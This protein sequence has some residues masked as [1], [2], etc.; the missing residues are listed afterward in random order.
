VSLAAG[1]SPL[2][3]AR[4]VSVVA[5]FPA[6]ADAS[7]QEELLL[8]EWL[9]PIGDKLEQFNVPPQMAYLAWELG[10]WQR[11]LDECERRCAIL[12]VLAASVQTHQGST[13]LDLDEELPRLIRD[14]TGC[15]EAGA[16][17][18]CQTAWALIGSGRLATIAGSSATDFKPLILVGKHLYLQKMLD[19]ED[20][21]VAAISGRRH[22]QIQRWPESESEAALSDV[23]DRPSV[24]RQGPIRLND[25]Q[26]EAV[27]VALCNALTVISGGPGTGKTTIVLSILRVLRRLGVACEEV[28]LAAPTGKAAKRLGDSIRAGREQIKKPAPADLDLAAVAEPRTL[29]RLLGFSPTTSTFRYHENNRLAERVLIVDESSMIDLALMERLVRSL[30]DDSRLIL[31]GDAD[32]LPSVEAGTVLRDLLLADEGLKDRGGRCVRLKQSHRMRADDADGAN[33]LAV[34]HA[35]KDGMLPDFPSVLTGE[36]AV[37]ERGSPGELTFHG[38]EFIDVSRDPDLLDDFLEHWTRECS[39]SGPDFEAL[40]TREYALE[41]GAFA[42]ADEKEL[43]SLFEHR[44]RSGILCASRVLPTGSDRI[45]ALLHQRYVQRLWAARAEKEL[46]PGEPVMMQV[47]DYLRMIFNGDSGLILQVGDGERTR[48]MAVFRRSEGFAAFHLESLRSSLELSY[49]ITVHKAQGSEFDRVAVI[50]PDR[51][52][53]VN[54]REVLY[55]ALTRAR[56]SAVLLG[57]R[58]ILQQGIAKTIKRGSG[59]VEKLVPGC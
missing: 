23:L 56:K 38:V 37:M 8:L 11:G 27:R 44:E 18:Q 49:A 42:E 59:I 10:R 5:D 22:A 45:N 24:A 6:A 4:A 9:R 16:L 48:P 33:L 12:L 3:T 40:A 55:T 43:K 51:D 32:Q 34:A 41:R 19:L 39:S 47:N 13:R 15:E 50:L 7:A 52:V 54:T 17:R 29:H 53:P 31:L 46:L 14:L 58:E 57:S 26:R 35:F 36:A 1:L 2:G 20:R 30:R 21:F 25:E 28:A